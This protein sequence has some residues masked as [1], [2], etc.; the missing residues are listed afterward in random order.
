MKLP[1]EALDGFDEDIFRYKHLPAIAEFGA[2]FD[3]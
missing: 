2:E 1:V 3:R